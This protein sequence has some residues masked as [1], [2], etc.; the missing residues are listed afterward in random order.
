MAKKKTYSVL[1]KAF[2]TVVVVAASKEEALEI[3]CDALSMGDLQMDE[4]SVEKEL[5]TAQEIDSARRHADRV[6]EWEDAH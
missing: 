6:V 1:V 5:K 2:A 4:G 3:G